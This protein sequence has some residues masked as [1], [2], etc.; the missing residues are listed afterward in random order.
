[1]LSPHLLFKFFFF[2]YQ[3][4]NNYECT[5]KLFIPFCS[6]SIL[7]IT[8]IKLSDVLEREAVEAMEVE[9]EDL[10][11]ITEEADLIQAERIIDDFDPREAQD[12]RKNKDDVRKLEEMMLVMNLDQDEIQHEEG[13]EEWK[14]NS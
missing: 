6:F 2:L 4:Q 7:S 1:M 12:S 8:I 10:I 13:T 5:L 11:D 14:V 9:H 3:G